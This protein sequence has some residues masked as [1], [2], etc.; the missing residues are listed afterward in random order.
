MITATLALQRI[1]RGE[2]DFVSCLLRPELAELLRRLEPVT[3]PA[4]DMMRIN[5]GYVSGH[6][7]FFHPDEA[8]QHAF[9]LPP[10]SLRLA[11]PS[12]R[13]LK[14]TGLH[15]SQ[16]GSTEKLFFP[17]PQGDLSASE[18]R[19]IQH[20]E[21]RGVHTGH[22]TS[23]RSPWYVVP[24]VYVPDFI[25]PTFSESPVVMIN[26][27]ELIASNSL[28]CG[29]APVDVPREAIAA[30]WYTSLT[31]LECELRVHSLGGGVMVMIPGEASHI[32]L[33]ALPPSTA[34]LHD[35]NELLE[36]GDVD[37]AYA[38]GNDAV[39]R[40]GLGL[41]EAEVQLIRDGVE[42]LRRWRAQNRTGSH[43]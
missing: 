11:T 19:Y 30:A 9:D 20:G 18:H 31:L 42:S 10:S 1:A 24:G 35:V 39:L 29:F 17:D 12:S 27:A 36:T 14:R 7:S 16:I 22:K 23:R 28:L 33:S 41:S 8:T 6:K 15:T 37:A 43:W 38:T 25:L 5:I 13:S 40:Q 21:D 32:R 3:R 34:H 2:R 4:G 26:D